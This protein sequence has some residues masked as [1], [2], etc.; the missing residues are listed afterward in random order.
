MGKYLSTSQPPESL[1]E[2][3]KAGWKG[4]DENNL[5]QT[6]LVLVCTNC[7][8]SSVLQWRKLQ[9]LHMHIL[10]SS[11]QHPAFQEKPS[12]PLFLP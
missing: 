1:R 11:C 5:Q 10:A 7:C 6:Q 2:F 4:L 3:N 9:S 8:L 12:T